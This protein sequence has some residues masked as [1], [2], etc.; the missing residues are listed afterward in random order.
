MTRLSSDSWGVAEH[1]NLA[2]LLTL[3]AEYDQLDLTNLAWAEAAARRMQT[4]EWVYHDKV[5]EN[6]QVAGDRISIEEMSAFSGTHRAGETTMICPALL[7]HVRGQV[8]T[9]V[10]IMKSVRKAREE[11]YLRRKNKKPGKGGAKGDGGE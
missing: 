1:E 6:E 3:S 5:R 7:S 10:G 8:E 4:I 2:H 9:D 11:R